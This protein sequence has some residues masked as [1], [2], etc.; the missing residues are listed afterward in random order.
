MSVGKSLF[1]LH[2]GFSAYVKGD[3]QLPPR[4]AG[5]LSHTPHHWSLNSLWQGSI[6]LF[7]LVLPKLPKVVSFSVLGNTWERKQAALLGFLLGI[8]F[9]LG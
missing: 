1:T 7:I 6:I 9:P 5:P 4:L 2:L 8:F 3:K